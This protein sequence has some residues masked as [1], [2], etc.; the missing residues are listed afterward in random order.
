MTTERDDLLTR[1]ARGDSGA[2]AQLTDPHRAELGRFAARTLGG[3]AGLAEEV[4]QESLLKAYRSIREGARPDN[5]RAWLYAIVRNGALN[6]RRDR[7][8]ELP[9]S[10]SD[11]QA[12][13]HDEASREVELREWMDWLMGAIGALPSRQRDVLVAHAFEGRN[14]EE[15]AG[16]MGTSVPAVKTLLHRAR[17]RLQADRPFSPA[18]LPAA[19]LTLAGRVRSHARGI[20]AAKLGTKGAVATGWQVLVVATIA[21]G[22]AIVAHGGAGPAPASALT[23]SGG[24][25][26]PAGAHR[27]HHGAKAHG[28]H[29]ETPAARVRSEGH[30]AIHECIRGK[31]L[32]PDLS[33]EALRFATR[34]LTQAAREYTE[35]EQVFRNAQLRRS[36]PRGH[37]RGSGPRGHRRHGARRRSM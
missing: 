11:L 34:H 3:D 36:R 33:S 35:C 28:K 2:F 37:A 19:I 23:P 13:G 24:V 26:A 16:S 10:D 6:A 25:A 7:R 4:V 5:V 22:V 15:I 9:L 32:S 17:R 21:T 14:H 29:H 20:L 18:M 12:G 1:V 8:I 27:G 31:R 30:R